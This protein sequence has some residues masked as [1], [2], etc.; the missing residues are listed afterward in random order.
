MSEWVSMISN[1]GFPIVCVIALAIYS[2]KTTNRVIDLTEKVT[3]ALANSSEKLDELAKAIN[4]LANKE[5]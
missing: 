2:Y 5:V 3:N 4:K 1:L